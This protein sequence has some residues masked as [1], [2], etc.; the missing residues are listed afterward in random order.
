MLGITVPLAAAVLVL[1]V[2]LAILQRNG[3]L[4][5]SVRPAFR[6]PITAREVDDMRL[7]VLELANACMQDPAAVAG[8]QTQLAQ[9]AAKVESNPRYGEEAPG[10]TAALYRMYTASLLFAPK[11]RPT[12]AKLR[13]GLAALRKLRAINPSV[14]TNQDLLVCEKYFTKLADG[15]SASYDA[16]GATRHVVKLA[17]LG[18]ADD[19]IDEY[20]RQI[21][22][23]AAKENVYQIDV[24]P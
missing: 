22:D 16:Y 2:G 21:V 18:S 8:R 19:K 4:G 15:T 5:L 9:L 20:T 6:P 14:T 1:A 7:E 10:E 17:L 3:G 13:R 12:D 11:E 24:N 23:R